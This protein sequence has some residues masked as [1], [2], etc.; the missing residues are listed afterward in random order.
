MEA[1]LKVKTELTA[2][3]GEA[4]VAEADLAEFDDDGRNPV[5]EETSEEYELTLSPCDVTRPTVWHIGIHL[6]PS[7]Q[8]TVDE[9]LF[10]LTMRTADATATLASGSPRRA[11]SRR[12][13]ASCIA[14]SSGLGAPL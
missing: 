14:A 3:V 10:T 1:V 5:Y 6:Q 12:S 4:A 9:T 8:A 7:D 2:I 11:V 13:H